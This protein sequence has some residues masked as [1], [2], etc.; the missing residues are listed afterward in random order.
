MVSKAYEK[1]SDTTFRAEY[2]RIY[3][4]ARMGFE[5]DEVPRTR[6]SAFEAVEAEREAREGRDAAYRLAHMWYN[7]AC[8]GCV[9]R[10][11]S[12][13]ANVWCSHPSGSTFASSSSTSVPRAHGLAVKM[14]S[15]LCAI[16][17]CA[18]KTP[19]WRI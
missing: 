9:L 4:G 1:L 15:H 5:T 3:V 14:M 7:P 13:L 10:E 17:H 12:R 11:C 2:D 18:L 16:E 19:E 8:V 6:T